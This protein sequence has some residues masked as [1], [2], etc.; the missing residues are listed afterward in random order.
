MTTSDLTRQAYGSPALNG[1]ADRMAS[2][3]KR[4][5]ISARIERQARRRALIRRA[6][7]NVVAIA[8]GTAAAVGITGL[9]TG[10]L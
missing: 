9:I 1:E 10:S 5:R 8:L 3:R 2:Q 6:V 7:V 4:E